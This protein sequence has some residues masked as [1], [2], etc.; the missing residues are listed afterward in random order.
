[1]RA[2]IW[3]WRGRIYFLVALVLLTTRGLSAAEGESFSVKGPGSWVKIAA[4][5]DAATAAAAET[6]TS[7]I[8]LNDHQTRV[9]DRSVERY[10][11]RVQRVAAQKDLEELSQIQIDFEPSY[12]SLTIHHIQILRGAEVINAYRPG[13]IQLLHREKELDQQIF[14]GSLQAVLIL[15]DVRLGDV[16]DF[17]YTLTGSNPVLH[18]KFAQTVQLESDVL[19]KRLRVRL[20]WPQ[21]RKLFM[22]AHNTNIEPKITSG[23]EVEYLWERRDAAPVEGEG[24]V[25]AWYYWSPWVD[26]SEFE[27]WADVVAWGLP[28]YIESMALNRRISRIELNPSQNRLNRRKVVCLLH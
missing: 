24:S 12:Q 22:R 8:L 9:T 4:L 11:R 13:E 17:A 1:M 28:I 10:V 7:T 18:G 5:D 16:I 25:P 27:T 19:V 20:L 14:D 15:S 26:V 23:E 21:K 2:M 6:G 3:G